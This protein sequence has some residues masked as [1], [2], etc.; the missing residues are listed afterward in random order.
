MEMVSPVYAAL[1]VIEFDLLTDLAG[2]LDAVVEPSLAADRSSAAEAA[3]PAGR[4]AGGE[5]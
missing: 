5:G 1:G 2:W 3:G 4:P